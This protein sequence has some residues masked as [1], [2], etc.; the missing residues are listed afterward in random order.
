VSTVSRTRGYTLVALMIGITVMMV[1]IAAVLPLESTE[2]QRHKEAEL[3]FRGRQY[4]EGIRVFH[5]RYGRYPT[6]LKEMFETKPRTLRKLWK[7]PL[8][9]S[10]KWGIVS[11]LAGAP[12]PGQNPIQNQNLTSTTDSSSLTSILSGTK[13]SGT[14]TPST[15]Q[16]TP[17]PTP[18]PF[19][20]KDENGDP[21]TPPG[22]IAGVY[23]L[24]HKKSIRLFQGRDN[25][26]DWRFTEQT[27]TQGDANGNMNLDGVVPGVG[28]VNP[29]NTGAGKGP[30]G[31][32]GPGKN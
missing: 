26:A 14:P 1:L 24:S 20:K 11:A 15:A 18:D 12:V 9:N 10:E 22:P 8:T 31:G 3:I 27:L 23:S 6:T 21:V 4:A 32:G 2:A 16:A 28:G 7:D 19:A 29:T 13:T 5:R 30:P 25:Y 17:G